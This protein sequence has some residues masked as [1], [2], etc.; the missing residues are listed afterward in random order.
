MEARYKGTTAFV[1]RLAGLSPKCP[2]S[3]K[4]VGITRDDLKWL[5]L[6]PVAFVLFF[7]AGVSPETLVQYTPLVVI[8][9]GVWLWNKAS[10]IK[11]FTEDE[12]RRLRAWDANVVEWGNQFVCMSCNEIQS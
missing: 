1:E 9:S 2:V 8:C 12:K 5:V 6:V 11:P 3:R 4:R 10:A 7:F